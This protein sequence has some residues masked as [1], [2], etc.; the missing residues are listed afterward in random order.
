MRNPAGGP[1]WRR[2]LLCSAA[3][4]VARR[5]R[6]PRRMHDQAIE[7][8]Y[9]N[10][11]VVAPQVVDLELVRRA[12]RQINESIGLARKAAMGYQDLGADR[13]LVDDRLGALERA[14]ESL[15]S[16][17]THDAI[18]DLFNNSG[19]RQFLEKMLGGD[20]VP[21]QQEAQV[22]VLYPPTEDLTHKMGQMGWANADVPWWGWGGHL[23]GGYNGGVN[24]NAKQMANGCNIK[25]FTCLVGIPLNDQL[26]E[27]VGNLGVLKTAHHAMEAVFQRQHAAGGAIGPDGPGW[28]REDPSAPD[29]QGRNQ[30]SPLVRE[31]FRLNADGEEAA[32]VDGRV[33]PKPTL[34]KAAAGDC[35]VVKHETPHSG[36]RIDGPDPRYMIYFRII[37]SGRPAGSELCYPEAMTDI[38]HEWPGVKKHM[39]LG[40][41]RSARL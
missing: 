14:S 24:G 16:L 32:V 41:A 33:W 38:W 28:P 30:Y 21:T 36:T 4:A 5:A 31:Q 26:E 12:R 2:V 35:I 9:R 17:G 8:L 19:A 22:Q 18:L 40:N 25:N 20:S 39:R 11:F 34:I 27:G 29:G 3:G 23:D 37:R 7:G 6:E 13:H 1:A 10:G 15:D